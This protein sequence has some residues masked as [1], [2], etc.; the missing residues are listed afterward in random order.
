[1]L[2][3]HPA[4]S[5]DQKREDLVKTDSA[6]PNTGLAESTKALGDNGR[7]QMSFSV[8]KKGT[9]TRAR[10]HEVESLRPTKA[11]MKNG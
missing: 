9:S 7:L 11:E 6:K 4:V 3:N 8:G 5:K 2:K 10:P 1:M